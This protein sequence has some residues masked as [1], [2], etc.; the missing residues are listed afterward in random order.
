MNKSIH[1]TLRSTTNGTLNTI[2][3]PLLPRVDFNVKKTLRFIFPVLLDGDLVLSPEHLGPSY[4]VAVLRNAGIECRIVEVLMESDPGNVVEDIRRW[5]PDVVG[6]SLTTIGVNQAT[7]FGVRLKEC[8]PHRVFILGGGP[9]AT[10]LGSKLLALDKWWF[11]DGLIRGEGEAPI[12]RFAEALFAQ[13]GFSGVPNLVY[14]SNNE[15]IENPLE[16]ALNDLD[17]FPD[18]VRD[19]YELHNLRFPYL[20]IS[21][22]RGCTSHC[23]FC[24]APHT[25]N[26]VGPAVKGWRGQCASRVVDEIERLN[27]KY[28][29]NTFD[30]VDSTF[31][32]PGGQRKGKERVRE[33]A[34]EILRRELKIYYNICMQACNWSEVDR[35]LLR[36]LW[37]SGLE[38]VLVGI[39]S[40]SEEG[41][42]RW[43]KL[44]TVE[45]NV[46]VIQLLREQ[47]VY[48]AFGFISFHPHSTFEEI[49]AN[50]RFLH[51]NMGH[52]L[53]RYTVRLELYPGAEVVEQL[54]TEG[55][56]ADDY[57]LHLNPFAY[58]YVD[59][60]VQK[61][62][63]ALNGLYGKEYEKDCTISKEPAVFVFETYDIVLHTYL[64]RLFRLYANNSAVVE[65]L[66]ECSNQVQAIKEQIA[67]FN[68]DLV[69][70]YVDLAEKD[71]LTKQ[72]VRSRS[73]EVEIYYKENISNLKSLQLRTSMRLHRIGVSVKNIAT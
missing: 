59:E 33:I 5:E 9:L 73:V 20:R 32:D 69:S 18:P 48:V 12:L 51:S 44:S 42:S 11:M 63:S 50:Y 55:L 13:Q 1:I 2:H 38:K 29:C 72:I 54:R 19:Q 70:Q 46:R 30:F 10:H 61:L 49:R 6:L 22:S 60:R 65:I 58:R 68:Y 7:R 66:T 52:N 4:L 57:D 3:N 26:R 37:E 53:R 25:R 64:S 14:R 36:L 31:E 62:A 47:N 23:T 24:N 28:E 27:R 8:L 17:I 35:P 15:V 43:E 40:G 56:L 21:T 34:E 71:Q 16:A 39:E 41:L 67:H 45:D